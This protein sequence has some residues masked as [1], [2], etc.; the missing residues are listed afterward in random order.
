MKVLHIHFG[1]EGGAERFFVNLARALA[2]CGVEQRFVIRPGRTWRPEIAPL[3][4]IIENHYRNL[5]VSKYITRRR[6]HRMIARWQPQAIVAWMNRASQLVQAAGPALKMTRLGD[7]PKSLK[8]YR[9]NDCLVVNTPGI[10]ERCRALGWDR[11]VHVITNFP[12]EVEPAPVSRAALDTPEDAFVVVGSGRFVHRKGFDTLLRAVARLPGAW[13]WLVGEG[14]K[15]AEL[16]ALARELGIAGRVRFTG[17]VDEPMHYV[18]AGDAYVMASRHE[19]LGNV[20]LESW[21]AGVP[22]VTTRSEGPMWFVEDGRD[23]LMVDIDDAGA[24]SEALAR[25]RADGALAASLVR[26]GREKLAAQFSKDVIVQR[27]LD[28]FS[29]RL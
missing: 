17:W 19:P 6:V 8:H 27:Y 3:G 13:A 25:I 5:S 9:H 12:R 2:G 18:A 4:P 16:E 23:A 7:Y 1:K 22:V 11:P 10:A 24:M 15:R 20:I 28:L 26:A 14:E 21:R 29:G